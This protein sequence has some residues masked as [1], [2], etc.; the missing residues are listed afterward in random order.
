MGV[1]FMKNNEKGISLIVLVITIIVII[2][3]A[4][5]VILSL[6]ANNP[7]S[8]AEKAK[9]LSDVRT[10]QTELD[11]YKTK[12]F[13]DL[14]GVYNPALLDA[15]ATSLKYNGVQ[16]GVKTIYDLIPTLV[17]NVEYAGQFEIIDGNLV[18]IGSD[19]D[20]KDWAV[21]ITV[22]TDITAPI[23]PSL[24]QSP[25]V[26]TNGNVTVTI[27]Y[28][29]DATVKE[30]STDAA[31][32]N[33]YTV[34]VVVSTNST[35]V[36]ARAKDLANNVSTQSSITVSNIDKVVPTVTASNGGST[37]SGVTVT[38][39]ASDTGG[40]GLLASSY[41]YSKDN[42]GTWTTATSATTYAYT[43]LVAG[44]YQCKVK[45]S[46]N[47]TNSTTSTA[48]AI[49]TAAIP[50]ITLVKSPTTWTNGNVTVT[51]TF[52]AVATTKLY[53]TDGTNFV[54]YTVPVVV[55]TNN[56]T[57]YAKGTDAGGNVVTQ[58]M[59]P[60][61]TID[62]VAPTLTA[63]NGGATVTSVTVTAV[64]AADT[65]GSL[66]NTASYQYSSDNGVTWTTASSATTYTFSGIAAGT[67]QC[68]VKVADIAGNSTISAA[69]A[70]ARL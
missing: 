31:T 19:Q 48:V 41:Q 70:I 57:V 40:S 47:A 27:T 38:A 23:S 61:T 17:S 64:G 29:S 55:T 22:S 49:T 30:Y 33:A 66:L 54:A 34:P 42:G 24:V 44:T 10:F 69:V 3:L 67:Y 15:N 59:L 65:G 46:D 4:G 12:K 13:A 52:P 28:P 56:T 35:I 32:W 63:G 11:L 16:D 45:V 36:Y 43:G 58:V 51:V 25:T 39:V 60:V 7:I 20:K 62:K 1:N 8:Q 2:I 26:A 18:Y 53:S 5:A 50:A 37:S 68:K 21:A 14:L 9:Y 6:S